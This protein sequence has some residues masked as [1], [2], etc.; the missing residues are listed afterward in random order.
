MK[1]LYW[2]INKK[3]IE[4]LVVAL[5][6]EHE[7]DIIILSECDFS[8]SKLLL[9]INE[10]VKRK[11]SLPFSAVPGPVILIRLPRKSLKIRHDSHGVSV[12]NLIP[13]LGLDILIVILHLPSKLFY[14]EDDHALIATRLPEIIEEEEKKIGHQRTII[15]GDLNMN[16]FEP[17]VVGSEGL[18]AVMVR[19][20]AKK[21]SRFVMDKERIFF[22][23]PMWNHFG[24]A[25]STP[26]GTYYYSSSTPVNYY[27]NMYDQILIR[28]DLLDYF[29]D[30]NLKILTKAG[31]VDLLTPSGIPNKK[32]ASDHLPIMFFLDLIKG[33]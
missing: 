23:N 9:L 28:P 13:P 22:Y 18:H 11:Y 26:P 21:K 27:W 8:L 6:H 17:G 33:E 16:P 7:L 5:A 10:P 29:D 1:F 31:T 20:I 19:D 4:D 32:I 3:P 2:N 15:V 14:K 24:D 25:F 12:R 30:N